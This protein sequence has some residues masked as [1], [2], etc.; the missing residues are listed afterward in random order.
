MT[1]MFAS[2]VL[3]L[4]RDLDQQRFQSELPCGRFSLA[5]LQIAPGRARPDI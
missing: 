4:S 3:R 1:T 2:C 5:S